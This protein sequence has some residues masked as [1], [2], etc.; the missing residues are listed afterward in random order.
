M[1]NSVTYNTETYATYIIH[2]TARTL[3]TIQYDLLQSI[4][5]FTHFLQNNVITPVAY[6]TNT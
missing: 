5:I 6:N 2:N 1:F 4:L 3:F